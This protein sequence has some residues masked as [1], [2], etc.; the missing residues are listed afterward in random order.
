M[1]LEDWQRGLAAALNGADDAWPLPALTVHR[2]NVRGARVQALINIYPVLRRVLGTRCFDTLARRYVSET[3]SYS[4]DLNR[5]GRDFPL[6]LRRAQPAFAELPYLG[7]LARL[8]RA[9]HD[10]YY[11]P[12]DTPAPVPL[13][14]EAARVRPRLGASLAL[15]ASPWPVDAIWHAN[16][17]K[18]AAAS[19]AARPCRAVVWRRGARVRVDA[20]TAEHWRWLRAIRRQE[21]LAGLAAGGLTAATLED[22]MNKG[23]VV[24]AAGRRIA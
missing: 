17:D 24:C 1:R 2:R 16:R 13:L 15:I 4:A 6:W 9:V 20:I 18:T 12:D 14:A 3:P 21:G 5:A 22:F 8:E 11:A 23:W 19:V 7:D 10:A